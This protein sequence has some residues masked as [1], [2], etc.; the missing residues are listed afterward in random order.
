MHEVDEVEELRE[1]EEDDGE[2]DAE[3]EQRLGPGAQCRRQQADALVE[4]QQAQE[5]DVAEEDEHADHVH[6]HLAPVTHI[7]EFDVFVAVRR[8]EA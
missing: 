5:L 1:A 8:S 2:D 4:A 3:H 6:E 7:L